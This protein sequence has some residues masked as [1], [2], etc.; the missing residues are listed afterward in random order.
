MVVGGSHMEVSPE[1]VCVYVFLCIYVYA[2]RLLRKLKFM[3]CLFF[4]G[5][6]NYLN[7]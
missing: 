4:Y 5:T 6:N 7:V 1:A 2:V 3:C